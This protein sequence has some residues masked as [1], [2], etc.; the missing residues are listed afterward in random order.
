[1]L[2]ADVPRARHPRQPRLRAGAQGRHESCELRR[3]QCHPDAGPLQLRLLRALVYLDEEPILQN[4]PTYLPYF[5]DDLDYTLEHLD[6]LVIKDVAEAGGYGVV[7]GSSLPK[8]KQQALRDKII[9][10]PRRFISQQV[11]DFEDLP[12]MDS[13]RVNTTLRFL[14]KYYDQ[15]IDGQ[16]MDHREICEPRLHLHGSRPDA[17]Q[18]HDAARDHQLEYTLVPADGFQRSR[19]RQE[20]RLP[21]DRGA[22]HD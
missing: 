18:R 11:I 5:K 8:E 12:I 2:P 14:M 20:E 3:H 7:F 16:P 19:L 1:M 22:G 13:E 17:R 6:D 10:E 15:L 21:D 9:E 4:A